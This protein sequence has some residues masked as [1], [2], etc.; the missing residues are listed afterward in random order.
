MEVACSGSPAASHGMGCSVLP[1]QRGQDGENVTSAATPL[2]FSDP[3]WR[4]WES[5]HGTPHSASELFLSGLF[6]NV[7][8]EI[9]IMLPCFVRSAWYRPEPGFSKPSRLSAH[10]DWRRSAF[11]SCD[12]FVKPGG[13][14]TTGYTSKK[15]PAWLRPTELWGPSAMCVSRTFNSIRMSPCGSDHVLWSFW[16]G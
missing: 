3:S 14:A 13:V 1:I 9:E 11:S 15:Q 10:P 8:S 6:R 5:R 4:R 12:Y 16:P 2:G 7:T